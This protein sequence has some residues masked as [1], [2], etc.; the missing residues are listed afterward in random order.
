[1]SEAK[2][3]LIQTHGYLDKMSLAQ[4]SGIKVE[5]TDLETKSSTTYNAIRAAAKALDIDKRYIEHYIHLNQLPDG[6][7]DKTTG[8]T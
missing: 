1:M 7:N 8:I 5:V 2:N 6:R 4:S 3:L